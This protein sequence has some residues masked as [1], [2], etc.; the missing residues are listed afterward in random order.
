MANYA[1][2][3]NTARNAFQ[4]GRTKQLDFRMKQLKQLYQLYEDNENAIL[5]A[6][7]TDLHKNK[8]ESVLAEL[9]FLKNDV[10]TF[11]MHLKEWAA[12]EK[13]PKGFVNMMD[14]V[15][16]YKE[17]YGVALVIGAWNYPFF[18]S[19]K[20]MAGAIAAG[21]CVI[22]KPSEVSPASAK[23]IAELVPKY[24]DKECYQVV[25]G[26]VPETTELLKERFD[27]IFYTG[28]TT[29]GKI[30]RAAANEHL[31]PVTLEL[32]GKSPVYLDSTVDMEKAAKRI[33]WG[34]CLNAG[35]TC[36]APDYILCTEQAQDEFISKAKNV[37]EQWYGESSKNSPDLG[38]I[39]SDRHFQRLVKLMS[40]GKVA[41][42]GETDPSQKYISPTILVD[43]KPS[44]P[45]MQEEIFG[46]LLPIITIKDANEAIKF[47]NSREKPLAFY[48][49]T[50]NAKERKLLIDSVSCGGI[51]CND[52]IMHLAVESLP[53]GGVGHS[54]IGAYNGYYS[55]DTFTHKKSCLVKDFSVLGEKLG[56]SRYPPYTEKKT[57][58]LTMLLLK[59][60]GLG[61]SRTYLTHTL[62]FTLGILATLGFRTFLKSGYFRILTDSWNW[63]NT[64]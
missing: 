12:P 7:A 2:I 47:I 49:F 8:Y 36:V 14:E 15:L 5:S 40:S 30:V 45:I 31:T 10:K 24:L 6:L 52:T 62:I 54:G 64:S 63:P 57:N 38:R 22:L 58:F 32:G 46:P 21:N 39:V 27:Y 16:I 4:T 51:C 37:L 50:E 59:R 18:L 13:P 34:K 23:L 1:D 43:V 55:F 44:D 41:V 61:L 20:P 11:L 29:V 26:G 53:F 3:V 9:L 28:S 48:I 17:P 56:S 19:F 33:L 60:K 35:Q 42:G 25:L